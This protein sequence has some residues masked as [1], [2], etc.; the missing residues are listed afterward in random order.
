MQAICLYYHD[1]TK[2]NTGIVYNRDKKNTSEQSVFL[3]LINLKSLR[4]K[5]WKFLD[6]FLPQEILFHVRSWR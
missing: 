6:Y 1:V 5:F 3:S 4:E 2:K